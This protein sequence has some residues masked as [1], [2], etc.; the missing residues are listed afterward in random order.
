[1]QGLNTAILSLVFWFFYISI[2]FSSFAFLT[3]ISFWRFSV[4]VFSVFSLF[5]NC[6]SALIFCL[7]VT[8]SCFFFLKIFIFSFFSPKAPVHS[9]VFFVVGSSS[10]G[11]WDA[12]SAWSDEQCHVRAQDSN[13]Q[14]T[15]P[16]AVER[17]NLTTR[18]QGPHHQSQDFCSVGLRILPQQEI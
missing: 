13:Q 11:M 9:C 6:V 14:N 12:A 4:E 1:M 18:P 8:V 16:P 10:C 7:V 15:G 3:A 5:V 2:F 17:A